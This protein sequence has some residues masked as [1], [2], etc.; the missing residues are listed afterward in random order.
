MNQKTAI[1]IICA[2]YAMYGEMTS[3]AMRA[4]AKSKISYDVFMKAKR[5]GMRIHQME[6][7]W[8]LTK[9]QKIDKI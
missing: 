5:A 1:D 7:Q 4:Y 8:V 2:E 6:L 3:T 9:N